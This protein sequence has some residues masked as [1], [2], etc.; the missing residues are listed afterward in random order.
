[1]LRKHWFWLFLVI[2]FLVLTGW[3]YCLL[4]RVPTPHGTISTDDRGPEPK[5]VMTEALK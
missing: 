5:R 1:M 3:A 2:V 4:S